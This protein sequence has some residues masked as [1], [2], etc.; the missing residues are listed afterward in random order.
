MINFTNIKDTEISKAI[1]QMLGEFKIQKYLKDLQHMR[2]MI[3]SCYNWP[4]VSDSYKNLYDKV[5]K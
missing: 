4:I 3:Y 5:I 1:N 2:K